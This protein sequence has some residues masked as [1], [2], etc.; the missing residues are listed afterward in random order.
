[1]TL[2][3]ILRIG[4]IS[5]RDEATAQVCKLLLPGV[6]AVWRERTAPQPGI[7]SA[8]STFDF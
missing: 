4:L 5:P 1:M 6:K 2:D 7:T 8:S 3:K